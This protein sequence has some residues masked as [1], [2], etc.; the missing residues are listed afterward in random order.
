MKKMWNVFLA[1]SRTMLFAILAVI[2]VI[3]LF[4]FQLKSLTPGISQAELATYDSARSVSVIVDNPVN[5]PYKAGVF[6][7]THV[8]DS[9]FGLRFTGAIIGILS[10][11]IFF[12]LI[13]QIF[14]PLVAIATTAMFATSSYLLTMS[15]SALPSVTLLTL[16]GIVAIGYY[17]RFGKRKDL[18]WI[19]AAAILGISLYVPGMLLFLLPLAAW[20]FPQIRKSFERLQPPIIIIAS[21]TF[22]LLCVPLF[23]SIVREPALWREYLGIPSGIAPITEMAKYSATAIASLFIMSP[24]DPSI[25]LGR[26]PILDVFATAMFIYGL[27]AIAKQYRLDRFWLV[28]GVFLISILWIGFTTNRYG[29]ILLLPFTYLVVGHG[30]QRL[31]RQWRS[32]FPRNPIARYTGAVL[33][34]ITIAASVNFQVHRYFVAWPH[35]DETKQALQIQFPDTAIRQ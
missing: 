20:Q 27:V 19:G 26:Q 18:G 12:L 28:A 10:V 14:D 35:A 1:M 2:A 8:F 7:S 29:L 3:I 4:L 24:K 30:L 13:R 23:V 16:L 32:V 11:V 21:V 25:W 33:L 31:I 22:G 9:A 15:R 34:V 6:V 17:I 5:A